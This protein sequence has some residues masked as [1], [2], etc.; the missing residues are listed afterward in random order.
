M[1]DTIKEQ[2]TEAQGQGDAATCPPDANKVS[3]PWGNYEALVQGDRYQVKR[4]VIYPGQRLSLQRHFHRAEHWVVVK[5][6]ALATRGDE[7]IY[8]TENESTYIPVGTIHRLENPGKLNL[9]IIEVQSGVYLGEDDIVRLDDA[10]GRAG[11]VPTA[12]ES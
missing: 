8:L 7:E 6:T 10:Y 11:T 4:L 3:R 9:E 1:N 2:G 12:E 5:G